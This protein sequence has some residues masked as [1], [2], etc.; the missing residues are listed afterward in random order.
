MQIIPCDG[1]SNAL[2]LFPVTNDLA[3]PKVTLGC[4]A[5]LKWFGKRVVANSTYSNGSNELS[6]TSI[7]NPVSGVMY[8]LPMNRRNGS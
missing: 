8:S 4:E 1:N 5:N 2:R 7:T 3:M 6:G